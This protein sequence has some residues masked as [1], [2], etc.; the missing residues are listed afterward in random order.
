M[1]QTNHHFWLA[2]FAIWY[3]TGGPGYAQG[4]P[5]GD[6][7]QKF[8]TV[9]IG[10]T[11]NTLEL[12]LENSTDQEINNI[13][14]SISSLSSWVRF[15][16]AEVSVEA[17]EPNEQTPVS[18]FFSISGEAVLHD[19]T[20]VRLT[21]TSKQGA[22]WVTT[23]R[24]KATAPA[25]FK[26]FPNFPNPFTEGTTIRYNLPDRMQV[27]VRVYDLLGRRVA[28]LADEAQ[29]AGQYDL[30]WETGRIASGMYICR[31]VAEGQEGQSFVDQQKMMLVK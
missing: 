1:A 9:P 25:A 17:V 2:L 31:I 7:S 26:L 28:T 16:Q 22:L 27:R 30:R 24:L 5:T 3:C 21:A 13:T 14:L 6:T 10:S 4:Q 20:S 8:H 29:E 12:T 15:K 18:F 23:I 19:T 11:E